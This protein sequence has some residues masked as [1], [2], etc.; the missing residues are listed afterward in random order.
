MPM[1]CML[2]NQATN[3][4]NHNQ[5]MWLP[6]WKWQQASWRSL[7]TPITQWM[8]QFNSLIRSKSIQEML[9][10]C[11]QTLHLTNQK[12]NQCT[13]NDKTACGCTPRDWANALQQKSGCLSPLLMSWM[14]AQFNKI[15]STFWQSNLWQLI[16]SQ[17]CIMNVQINVELHESDDWIGLTPGIVHSCCTI[18]MYS[19]CHHGATVK[20]HYS[21]P[22]IRF[23][24]KEASNQQDW[25]CPT[26]C[27][28]SWGK[29]DNCLCST[30][31]LWFLVPSVKTC[32]HFCQL[33]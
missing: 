4:C 30:Q 11:T 9:P 22:Q 7:P 15:N 2:E 33:Q 5:M 32:L 18:L 21:V 28:R 6:S 14:C 24:I 8:S 3:Q 31:M 13:K 23:K 16:A 10:I 29:N 1:A 26:A 19:A 20:T 17:W 27:L 12:A 25:S